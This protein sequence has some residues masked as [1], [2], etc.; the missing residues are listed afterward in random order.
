MAKCYL[1]WDA[2]FKWYSSEDNY[3]AVISGGLLGMS[4]RWWFET[5]GYDEHMLGWGGENLDQSLR[6]WLCGGEIVAASD[7]FVAHMWRSDDRRTRARYRHVGDRDANRARAVYAWYGEF[8]EKLSHYP[9]FNRRNWWGSGPWY[10]D[11][12]NI[13]AVKNR[14]GCRPF[15]WFLRRFSALYED[16]GMIPPEVFM[17]RERTTGK[18]LRYDG[19]AGTS[20]D[21]RGSASLA[22]CVAGDGDHRLLWHVANRDIASGSCCSGIRAWNTDQCLGDAGTERLETSVCDVSGHNP[23]QYAALRG[24]DGVGERKREIDEHGDLHVGGRCV[25]VGSRGGLL[26]SPHPSM[27]PCTDLQE[28][29]ASWMQV[30]TSVPLETRLY[31][32]AHEEHP[33]MFESA[34]RQS[35]QAISG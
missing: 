10:G 31:K 11:I 27:K 14:L 2:D 9:S 18:C 28:L 22:S 5:G 12:S 4:R 33:E 25:V 17:L 13:L 35:K 1:T 24:S 20:A 19:Y 32:A 7:S 26:W 15:S 21:G 3:V 29:G 34:E 30:S 16:A 23:Q 6:M 8:A